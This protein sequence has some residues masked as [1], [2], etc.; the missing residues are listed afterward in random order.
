MMRYVVCL[1]LLAFASSSPAQSTPKV[2]DFSVAG[3]HVI[4]KPIAANDV[5]AVQLF[6]KGGAAAL[7]SANAGIEQLIVNAA[8][9]GTSKYT[10][11]QFSALATKAGAEISGAASL[12]F[13]AMTLRAALPVHNDTT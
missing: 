6:V 12:E 7:S 11:E 4:H 10:K 1:A 8:P 9:L 5:V 2:D 13:T 3:I